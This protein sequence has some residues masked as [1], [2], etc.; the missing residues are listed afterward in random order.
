M[1]VITNRNLKEDETGFDQFGDRVNEKGP[2]E[3]RVVRVA[4]KDR[5]WD[6]D[7]LDE[8]E[9]KL[10]AKEREQLGLGADER[11][12]P[13]HRA[14][15][16]T[17]ASMRSKKR[18][19][20]FYIHGFK[21]DM[22]AV[23]E[24]CEKLEE[25]FGVEV[26]AFSWPTDGG[27]WVES[28]YHS[29]KLDARASAGAVQ[30]TLVKVKTLFGKLLSGTDFKVTL[31]THSMGNYLYEQ[32]MRTGEVYGHEHFFDN[33]V[34]VAPDCNNEDHAWWVNRIKPKSRLYITI[35]EQDSIL[36]LSEQLHGAEQKE[37]LGQHLLNLNSTSARYINFSDANRVFKEHAYFEDRALKTKVVKQFFTIAF[38]GG[39]AAEEALGWDS[40][41]GRLNFWRV[42][43]VNQPGG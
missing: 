7:I 30:R 38:N 42:Q 10:T 6:V 29:D 17:A 4:K 32:I 41:I 23:A 11:A 2:H 22:K 37:R 5:K 25:N 21:N 28:R 8:D 34:M 20:L 9:V 13:S 12:L 40:F 16:D 33:I 1:Y 19:L 35:N 24:R 27:G 39:K 14:A 15:L 26:M 36:G 43:R 3:L 31:L 18:N